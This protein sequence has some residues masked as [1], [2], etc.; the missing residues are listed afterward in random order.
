VDALSEDARALDTSER[1]LAAL[2]LLPERD[3]ALDA[4]IDRID[5]D[6]AHLLAAIIGGQ[7]LGRRAARVRRAVVSAEDAWPP[8]GQ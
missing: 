5:D 4:L 8:Y 3:E 1:V 6:R 2:R 7:A